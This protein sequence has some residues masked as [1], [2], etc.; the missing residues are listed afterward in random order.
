MGYLRLIMGDS[1]IARFW[2]ASQT[3]RP[4]ELVGVPFKSA[5]CLDTLASGLSDVTDEL[6]YVLVSVLTGMLVEEALASDA[7]G[8]SRGIISDVLKIVAGVAKKS[9]RVE[10]GF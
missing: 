9:S 8:S 7:I 6:D 2:Q 1:S 3:A 5:D 10:V 4:K